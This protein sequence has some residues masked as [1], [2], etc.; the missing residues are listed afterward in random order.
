MGLRGVRELF[1]NPVFLGSSRTF[2]RDPGNGAA[3]PD[4][5]KRLSDFQRDCGDFGEDFK[6]KSDVQLRIGLASGLPY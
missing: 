4:V 6:A 1:D 5:L 3:V 2:V